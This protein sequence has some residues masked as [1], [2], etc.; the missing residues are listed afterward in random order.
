MPLKSVASRHRAAEGV[1]FLDQMA[2]ADATNG[3]VA[4]HLAPRV[5]TLCVSKRVFTPMRA[6]CERCLGTGM[7]AADDDHVKTG[8]E[9]HH[10]PRACLV[11]SQ[12]AGQ[13][14]H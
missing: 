7:T 2:F 5:S 13:Y 10:A 8:R 9:I 4:A 1:D 6:D 3:W 11:E 14:R 12:E